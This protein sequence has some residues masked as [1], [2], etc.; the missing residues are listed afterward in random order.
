MKGTPFGK[1]CEKITVSEGKIEKSNQDKEG[2]YEPRTQIKGS[3]KCSMNEC[4]IELG[5]MQ[6]KLKV[7]TTNY[8]GFLIVYACDVDAL[9]AYQK[10][11]P[12]LE[13]P[14]NGF[15]WALTREENIHPQ[16]LKELEIMI[17]DEFSRKFDLKKWKDG[18]RTL[19]GLDR[20]NYQNLSSYWGS[21]RDPI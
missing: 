12:D 2:L 8:E 20:C 3:A 19:Q 13:V 5:G 11:N 16:A 7:I 1:V 18:E 10:K 15:L 9:E 4:E 6:V 21:K 17:D 14:E